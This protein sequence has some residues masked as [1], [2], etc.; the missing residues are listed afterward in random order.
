MTDYFGKHHSY[1]LPQDNAYTRK[2]SNALRDSLDLKNG[3]DILEWGA[4]PGAFPSPC[5]IRGFP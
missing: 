1:L 4:A 2:I 5:S 3:G